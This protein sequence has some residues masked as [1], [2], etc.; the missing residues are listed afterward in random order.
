MSIIGILGAPH[1]FYDTH[2]V[3]ENKVV[4]S[5]QSLIDVFQALGHTPLILPPGPPETAKDYVHLVDKIVLA[6]GSDVSPQ[7]YN[8]EPHHLL[9]TVNPTRDAFE[10]AALDAALKEKKAV[11]GICRGIQLINVYFGGTLYQ[12]LSLSASTQKHWQLPTPQ[13][14]PTHSVRILKESSLHFLPE[15]YFVN[16][17]HH[18]AIKQLAPELTAIAHAADG[19]VEAVENQEK[20]V[21]AVQW[22]PEGSWQTEKHDK[23]IFKYFAEEL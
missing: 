19:L 6:G 23:E 2:P 13:E 3:W 9:Q 14:I 22:H 7:L 17:F 4:F 11:L 10:L 15:H 18:Q 8:E 21:L 16:S 5:R 12:D 1:T 20:R